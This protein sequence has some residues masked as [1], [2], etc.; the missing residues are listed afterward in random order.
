MGAVIL[1]LPWLA[2]VAII[3]GTARRS[4]RKAAREAAPSDAETLQATLVNRSPP[5][6]DTL[7]ANVSDAT[8]LAL[9]RKAGSAPT[10]SVPSTAASPTPAPDRQDAAAASPTARSPQPSNDPQPAPRPPVETSA[11]AA[12]MPSTHTPPP[13]TSTVQV[14]VPDEVS[15]AALKLLGDA[16]RALAAGELKPASELLREVVRQASKLKLAIVHAAAR[17]DLAEIARAEGDL[18]TACEHWQIARGILH[19]EKRARERDEVTERMRAHRCPT[20]WV[21]TNF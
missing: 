3:I 1:A 13:A 2:L 15:R 7:P 21:L 18:T 12:R 14:N 9:D 17:L 11:E 8:K 19:E 4:R 16:R 5:A 6:T 20:D 10:S